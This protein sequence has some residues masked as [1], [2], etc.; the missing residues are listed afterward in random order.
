MQYSSPPP[1]TLSPPPPNDPFIGGSSNRMNESKQ[2][3]SLIFKN[4][5]TVKLG[6]NLKE[7]DFKWILKWNCHQ[8]M[9]DFSRRH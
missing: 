9:Y 1:P 5:F 6:S 4:D 3:S 2:M 7:I 8:T